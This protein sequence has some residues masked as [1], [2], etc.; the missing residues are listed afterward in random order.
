[1]R[2]F[3]TL[4]LAVPLLMLAPVG[5]RATDLTLL[6][7]DYPPFNTFNS[8]GEPE[9]LSVELVR[10]MLALAGLKG[11]VSL[12]PWLR[13]YTMTQDN[14]H[15]CLLSTTRTPEREA[16]FQWVGPLYDNPWVLYAPRAL[17]PRI[18]SLED[19]RPYRIAGFEGSAAAAYLV[20]KGFR[21]EYARD[22]L[23]NF[24]KLQAGRVDLWLTG[25]LQAEAL[26]ARR[27]DAAPL[28]P[29]ITVRTTQ[30]YL[31]CNRNMPLTMVQRLQRALTQLARENRPYIIAHRYLDRLRLRTQP[32][33]D[34][35]SR[36]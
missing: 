7:M 33:L 9:G 4:L 2:H 30:L 27:P 13:A 12:Y 11:S 32:A 14:R 31:A 10:D 28:E 18:R 34:P 1:M 5:A 8:T 17:A 20:K 25:R 15:A 3:C 29:R 6:A 24:T 22:D 35:W 21:V 16:L 36:R 26:M 19:A 23:D